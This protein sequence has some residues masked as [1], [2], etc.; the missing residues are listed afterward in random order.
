MEFLDVSESVNENVMNVNADVSDCFKQA[1][2]HLQFLPIYVV[3]NLGGVIEEVDPLLQAL[4]PCQKRI[5][6]H[7]LIN[8]F[9]NGFLRYN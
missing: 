2:N 7:K 6:F 9:S 3:L 4:L 8:I 5:C 1:Y